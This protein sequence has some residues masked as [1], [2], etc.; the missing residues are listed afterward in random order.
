MRRDAKSDAKK[1]DEAAKLFCNSVQYYD[2]E[3]LT[4][5]DMED[6]EDMEDMEDMEDIADMEDMKK[7][8]KTHGW[9]IGLMVVLVIIV[10]IV[11]G[12]LI[13]KFVLRKDAGPGVD[14][15]Y[16]NPLYQNP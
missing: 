8:C 5:K 16:Q 9:F 12:V 6:I 2:K 13:Y 1:A 7:G 10:L 4:P 3:S 14:P 11:I 15:S